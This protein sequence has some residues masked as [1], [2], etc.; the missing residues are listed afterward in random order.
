MMRLLL[1]GSAIVG[2]LTGLALFGRFKE[3]TDLDYCQPARRLRWLVFQEE[4]RKYRRKRNE[5][6]EPKK[7]F[8]STFK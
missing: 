5:E 1:V 4:L 7:D 6:M 8:S 2:S 3:K